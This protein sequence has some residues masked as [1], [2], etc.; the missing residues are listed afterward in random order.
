[1]FTD[2]H[3]KYLETSMLFYQFW[4][5]N[6]LFVLVFRYIDNILLAGLKLF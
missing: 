3:M 2:I 4:S 5:V 6:M 1:M